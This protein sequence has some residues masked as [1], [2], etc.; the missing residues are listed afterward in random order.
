[1]QIV[2][3]YLPRIAEFHLK[4]TYAKYRG[5]KSTPPASAY[6]A[7]NIWGTMGAYGGVDFPAIFRVIRERKWKGWALVDVDAPRPGDGTGS[8]DDALAA[9]VNYLRNTL[10]VRLPPPPS[11][12]A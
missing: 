7:G 11:A 1:M 3:D 4:D 9:N 12:R 2:K 8:I 6:A 5:N 10:Q